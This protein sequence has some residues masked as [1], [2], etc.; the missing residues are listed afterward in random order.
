MQINYLISSDSQSILVI[1]IYN[2][3]LMV[4][5]RAKVFRQTIV[6]DNIDCCRQVHTAV[7]GYIHHVIGLIDNLLRK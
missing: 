3:L 2:Y 6:Q 4:V 5:N 1:S 7:G